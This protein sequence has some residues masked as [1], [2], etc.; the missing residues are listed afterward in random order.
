MKKILFFINT[1]G[2]GGAEH[3][4]VDI[5]NNLDPSMFDI[6]IETIYDTNIYIDKLNNNIKYK[7]YY[8]TKKNKFLDKICRKILYLKLMNFSAKKLYRMLVKDKYNIEVAFLEGLPTKIISGS[9][10]KNSKKIAWV[11]SDLKMNQESKLFFKDFNENK[12]S[13]EEFNEIYCVSD[14]SKKSFEEIFNLKNNVYILY[15]IIDKKDILKKSLE[16]A[17]L[18]NCFNILNVGRLTKQKGQVR[19][20]QAYNEVIKKI[21]FDTHLYISG[22]GE[23][24]VSLEKEINKLG[25]ENHITLLGNQKNPYKYMKNCDLYVC[26]SYAEG[27]S[28]VILEALTL[29]LPVLTT[30]CAGQ[31][32]ILNNGEFGMIVKNDT[33]SLIK[34]MTKLLLNKEILKKYKQS[35]QENYSKYE[36][37]IKTIEEQLLK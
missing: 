30:D 33:E 8:K 26:S 20:I 10:N 32:Q 13:Y 27:Y 1:L 11:H 18:S 17:N 36:N 28:L 24:R 23:E 12:R 35:I 16:K 2:T 22:E 9:N 14:E 6:T 29:N 4:L 15:N 5:V 25:L 31:K 19:L 7:S 21:D 3:V 37:S 34:G